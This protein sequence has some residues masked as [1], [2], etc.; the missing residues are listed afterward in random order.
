[1][2]P[3]SDSFLKKKK[4]KISLQTFENSIL[5]SQFIQFFFFSPHHLENV[6]KYFKVA[7]DLMDY[8]IKQL[9]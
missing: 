3:M 5:I 4:K 2:F 8:L 7:G 9:N 6:L 1:M